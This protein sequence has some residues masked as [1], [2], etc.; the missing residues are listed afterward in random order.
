M[1]F[2]I[3]SLIQVNNNEGLFTIK[4]TEDRRNR[5]LSKIPPS[6]DMFKT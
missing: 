6:E 4:S 1:K 5:V 3:G 2:A